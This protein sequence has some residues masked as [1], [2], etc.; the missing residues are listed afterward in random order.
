[1]SVNATVLDFEQEKAMAILLKLEVLR[2]VKNGVSSLTLVRY[3][4]VL[5]A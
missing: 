5:N 4:G 1:M 3:V 2:S